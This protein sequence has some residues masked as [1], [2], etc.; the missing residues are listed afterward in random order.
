[1]DIYHGRR[2]R[3]DLILADYRIQSA[4]AMTDEIIKASVK[5]S[6]D[7]KLHSI[8]RQANGSLPGLAADFPALKARLRHL[9]LLG[10][11]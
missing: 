3:E 10:P 1:M 9:K 4:D 5:G 8:A 11:G 6:V 7:S 2:I